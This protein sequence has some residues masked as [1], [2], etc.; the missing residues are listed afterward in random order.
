MAVCGDVERFG[1]AVEEFDDIGGGW[2]LTTGEEMS[3]Y[4]VLW[5]DGWEGS[6]TRPAP[7]TLTA[8]ERKVIRRDF[9]WA[10]PCRVRMRYVRSR[11]WGD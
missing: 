7:Q 9:W 11:S 3:W 5:S 8:P 1:V 4:I 6:W 10:M 2:V